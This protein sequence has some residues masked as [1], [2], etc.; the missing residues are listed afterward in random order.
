[1]DLGTANIVISV[2]DSNNNPVAEV[3]YPS[4]IVK[5]GI[6]AAINIL[7]KLKFK[8]EKIIGRELQESATLVIPGIIWTEDVFIS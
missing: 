8:I 1:M 6:V 2:I 7:K 3:T 5:D 4:T